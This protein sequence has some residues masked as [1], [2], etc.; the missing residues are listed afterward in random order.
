ME[1]YAYSYAVRNNPEQADAARLMWLNR[2]INLCLYSLMDIGIHYHGWNQAQTEHFLSAFG[3]TDTAL[4]DEIFQYIVETPAN[5]LKY[6]LGYL[7]FEDLKQEMQ[8][9]Q[10]EDFSLKDFHKQLL[11]IGPAPFPVVRKYLFSGL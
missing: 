9:I 1:S 4:A 2:S 8:Q 6:Y 11:E 5:Y 7:N 3:V 10:Q